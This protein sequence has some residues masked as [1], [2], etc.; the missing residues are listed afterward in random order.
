MAQISMC[1]GF[2]NYL[3]YIMR[4]EQEET[5]KI[6]VL[7]VILG[8]LILMNVLL[9]A[10]YAV[11]P[12]LHVGTVFNGSYWEMMAFNT[13]CYIVSTYNNGVVLYR[14]KTR[15][16]HIVG[17]VTKNCV[18][19][20]AISVA[21][22]TLAGYDGISTRFLVAFHVANFILLVMWRILYH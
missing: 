4:T 9:A 13:L 15:N 10:L 1:S 19:F 22:I 11:W 12:Q 2:D 5:S 6:L 7:S 21:F 20:I 14:R 17:K 8:D 3:L 18:K 16:M